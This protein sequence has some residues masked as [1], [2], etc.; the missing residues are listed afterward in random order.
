MNSEAMQ[1][2]ATDKRGWGK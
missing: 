2:E 1:Y